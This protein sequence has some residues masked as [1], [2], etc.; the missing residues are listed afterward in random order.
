MIK[1][2]LTCPKAHEFEGWFASAIRDDQAV[3]DL[4]APYRTGTAIAGMA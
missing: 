2:Q 4:L 1:Y 3:T